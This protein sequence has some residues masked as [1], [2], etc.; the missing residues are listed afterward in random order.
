MFRKQIYFLI[1]LFSPLLILGQSARNTD[2]YKVKNGTFYFYP[3]DKPKG[4]TV[5][6]KGRTQAE[7][8][9]STGDTTFWKVNW[10]SECVF[11]VRFV[12]KS[13]P[14]PL[15]ESNF[16]NSHTTF[17]EVLK[18][19][20]DYYIFKG[21]LDSIDNPNALTDTMWLKAREP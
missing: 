3:P 19:L 17:F 11:D 5:I 12:R 9:L 7:I 20:K 4:F 10:K 14:M 2:C 13:S 6:R 21:G 15:H 1:T 18:C 16:F 8:D